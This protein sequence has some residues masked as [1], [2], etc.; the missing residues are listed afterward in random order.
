MRCNEQAEESAKFRVWDKVPEGSSLIF[1]DIQITIQHNLG[2]TESSLFWTKNQF[3]LLGY[4]NT[5][6]AC[7]Q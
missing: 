5:T 4:F 2:V 3:D 1:G 6:S 7:D